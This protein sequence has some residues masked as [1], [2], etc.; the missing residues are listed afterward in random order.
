MRHLLGVVMYAWLIPSLCLA[1]DVQP[2]AQNSSQQPLSEITFNGDKCTLQGLYGTFDRAVGEFTQEFLTVAT[3]HSKRGT[4]PISNQNVIILY[5]P[6]GNGK[7]E[8]A[9]TM[10]RISRSKFMKINAAAIVGTYQNSGTKEVEK[11]ALEIDTELAATRETLFVFFDEIDALGVGKG[12]TSNNNHLDTERAMQTLWQTLSAHDRTSRVRFCFA[13]NNLIKLPKQLLN[14]CHGENTIKM[15]NPD[16]EERKE[17]I[18]KFLAAHASPTTNHDEINRTLAR[19][20]TGLGTKNNQLKGMCH[21][22]AQSM[23]TID[24]AIKRDPKDKSIDEQCT[25]IGHNVQEITTLL[26][27]Q[28]KN[29]SLIP[30]AIAQ[31][32]DYLCQLVSGQLKNIKTSLSNL[33]GLLN[34]EFIELAARKA[35]G[36]SVRG[37]IDLT[38]A[39][40]KNVQQGTAITPE[41][42]NSLAAKAKIKLDL[43][44]QESI[45]DRIK[46]LQ[47][48]DLQEKKRLNTVTR[49]EAYL[50]LRHAIKM[51]FN[52][53]TG[54]LNTMRA[55]SRRILT[56]GS[57]LFN[58]KSYQTQYEKEKL[59]KIAKELNLNE[60]AKEMLL[61]SDQHLLMTAVNELSWFKN[62]YPL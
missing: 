36:V 17:K 55:P 10:A 48:D 49:L 21:T 16:L 4:A 7:T 41:I 6:P 28:R 20:N 58:G 2:L 46:A 43:E 12:D 56:E 18:G 52:F 60:H 5:G 51:N 45:D 35:E 24:A 53:E 34:K 37:L 47:L 3:D 11:I 62:L 29:T 44:R 42:I 8:L 59:E 9:R 50:Q 54:L 19:I 30:T 13:T 38:Q 32:M 57:A 26:S 25:S 15:D 31:D 61:A 22:L 33:P 14:R 27:R 1:S 39:I 40:H 23:A